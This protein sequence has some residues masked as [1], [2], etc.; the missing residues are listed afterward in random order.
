MLFL[1]G[2]SL[3]LLSYKMLPIQSSKDKPAGQAYFISDG[4]PIDNF[5][6]L[7]PLCNARGKSFPS[8]I[9][10]YALVAFISRLFEIYFNF[11]ESIGLTVSIPL[12]RA[13]VAKVGV[14]H[15]F[16]TEKAHR[17]LGYKP[18]FD[19][20]AGGNRLALYYSK[21]NDDNYFDFPA[22]Y[23]HILIFS[24]MFLLYRVAFYDSS[25]NNAMFYG[26]FHA[27]E[28]L[29]FGIFQTK[30]VLQIVFYAA[31]LTH[32]IEGLVALYIAK[33]YFKNRKYLWFVQTF[34]LGYPSLRLA[35]NRSNRNVDDS[36]AM[37]DD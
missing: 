3:P 8:L 4:S 14:T 26:G 5:I 36:V 35:L 1:S 13:E 33:R 6:F 34:L 37:S 12:N 27:I 24:G 23:W 22:F 25:S 10:P 17:E 29:A 11:C 20:T 31:V 7:K 16:S 28:T 18:A 30:F 9:V 21:W 32:F 15:T 2:S 19:S